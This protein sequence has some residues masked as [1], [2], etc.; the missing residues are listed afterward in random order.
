MLMG[1]RFKV[2]WFFIGFFL[3]LLALGL[4]IEASALLL[5]L[6]LHELGHVI[7]A[8]V[9]GYK[10]EKLL[11]LPLGG[12]M[13]L[14]Q[15][16]EIQPQ[17]EQ[18]IAFAGPLANLLAVAVSMAVIRYSPENVLL[19]SFIRANL[20]LA[21]FNLFPALPLDGGRVLRA[22]ITGWFSFYR[23][24]KLVIASGTLCGIVLL[25]LGVVGIVQGTPN[26]T[27]IAAGVFLLYNAYMEKKQLLVPMIRYVLGRQR[28]LRG[29]IMSA[30][31][32]VAAPGAKV[33]D[34]LKHIRPQRYYQISVLDEGYCISGILT[35]HQLLNEILTGTGQNSLQDVVNK[36]GG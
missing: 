17:A 2:S 24:T 18:K 22:W 11:L 12:Y 31:T 28:S 27:V 7:V 26:P 34:V 29:K 35:E 4:A 21:S 5:A 10:I 19:Y 8:K 6:I 30:Q 20:M 14:D 15:L 3:L 23:A 16:L 9:L 25:A 13:Y 1:K 36:K 32:L 33:N